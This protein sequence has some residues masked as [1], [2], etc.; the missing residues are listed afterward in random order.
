[1][2]TIAAA[3]ETTLER[4]AIG[5]I[6]LDLIPLVVQ[7]LFLNTLSFWT[8]FSSGQDKGTIIVTNEV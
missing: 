4:D 7:D 5:T 8:E 6:H 2:T 1:M 3:Q